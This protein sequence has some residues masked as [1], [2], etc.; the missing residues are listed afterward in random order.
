MKAIGIDIGTSGA[1]GILVSFPDGEVLATARRSYPLYAEGN[2]AEQDPADWVGAVQALLEELGP[3]DAIGLDGQMHSEVCLETDDRAILWCDGR[4]EAQC[5][6]IVRTVGLD[7]LRASVG[8]RPFAG[9]TLPHLLWRD[10]L[11]TGVVVCKDYVRNQLTGELRQEI[12]DAS[13]MLAWHIAEGRWADITV[14][15]IDPFALGP[16]APERILDGSILVTIVGGEV[17]YEKL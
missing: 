2:R 17:V 9:F 8:N 4:A 12:S 10:H 7:A 14:M 5:E 13:G 16:T 1:K 3:A 11:G 15:D 6:E